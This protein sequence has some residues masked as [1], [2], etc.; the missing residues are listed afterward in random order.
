LIVIAVIFV[1]PNGFPFLAGWKLS[2]PSPILLL[3]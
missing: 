1:Q 3:F 2:T